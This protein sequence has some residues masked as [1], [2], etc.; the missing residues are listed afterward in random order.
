M[1]EVLGGVASLLFLL[2]VVAL[3]VGLMRPRSVPRL[4]H[5]AALAA[6]PHYKIQSDSPASAMLDSASVAADAPLH[7]R[8]GA[9]EIAYLRGL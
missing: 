8:N 5:S 1:R 2:S 7:A 9:W 6:V 3:I 4:V